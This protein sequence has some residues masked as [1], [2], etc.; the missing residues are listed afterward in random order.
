M[1]TNIYVDGFNLYYGALKGTPYRWL[2]LNR[3]CSLLLPRFTIN[4]IKYFTARVRARRDDPAQAGRQAMYFRAL[5]TLPG[6]EIIFGHFLTNVVSMPMAGCEPENQKY[7]NVI[8]TEEKGSDVNLAAHLLFDGFK[9]N[10]QAAVVI[11]NDSD[12][13]EPIRIVKEEL[14]MVVGIMNPHAVPS[15]AL[16]KHAS[17]VKQIRRG[18][19]SVS[20]FP[21]ELR[22][23]KGI[24]RKPTTW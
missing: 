19:L 9:G 12:L 24:F 3:L 2:D 10:Y 18:V 16:I 7:V 1:L 6:L 11:T 20:Q 13:L 22:D 5:R 4:R 14:K 21:S 15:R 23:D 17:F 8:K